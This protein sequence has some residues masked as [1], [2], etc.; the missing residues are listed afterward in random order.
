MADVDFDAYLR[1]EDNGATM[2]DKIVRKMTHQC[3]I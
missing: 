2:L 3:G 1:D